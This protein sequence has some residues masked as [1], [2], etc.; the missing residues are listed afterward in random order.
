MEQVSVAVPGAV[1]KSITH[2]LTARKQ[3]ADL[4][5]LCYPDMPRLSAEALSDA[6]ALAEILRVIS[7]QEAMFSSARLHSDFVVV[8]FYACLR[9]A[10]ERLEAHLDSNP[11]FQ[12][13]VSQSGLNHPFSEGFPCLNV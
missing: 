5:Q 6:D 1:I 10:L 9:Q 13:A 7:V 2:P 3:L 11:A 4:V 12:Q 8:I